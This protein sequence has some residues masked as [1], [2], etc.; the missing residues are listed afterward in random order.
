MNL[1]KP[2]LFQS[3]Y[4]TGCSVGLRKPMR[5]IFEPKEDLNYLDIFIPL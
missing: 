3:S 1:L 5:S 4:D 2:Y